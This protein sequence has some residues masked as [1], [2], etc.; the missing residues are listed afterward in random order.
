[1]SVRAFLSA[2]ALTLVLGA[3]SSSAAPASTDTLWTL[4]RC[5]EAALAVSPTLAGTRARADAAQAG[6]S[7]AEASRFPVIGLSGRGGYT[8]ET[9]KLEVP[10]PTGTNSIE[11]GDGSSADL[12]FGLRAPLFT[13]G[14][15]QGEL[16]A[17]KSQRQASL[18][19]IA[20][21]SLEVRLQVRQA[22]F[23]ALGS[24]AA[25]QAAQ[26]GEERLRRHLA[27]VEGNLAVGMASEEARL[28]VLARL[29]RTEQ[30]TLQARAEAAARRY[31]LGQLV[32]L[33]GTQIYPQADLAASLLIGP[34]AERPWEKRPTLQAMDARLDAVSQS[35]RA[36]DGTRWPTVDLEGGWH[37]G[38][39]GIDAV[40]N[41]WMDYGTVAVNLRWT[42]FDFGSRR[43]RVGGLRAQQRALSATRDDVQD[44]LRTR[45]ANAQTQLETARQEV[46]RAAERLDLE[47]RRLEL[48]HE[49]WQEGH[50]T[51]SELL[52]AQDDV[53]LAESD[54]ATAQAR[55]RLTEAELLAA[56]GW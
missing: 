49:R 45:Q 10:T 15:L 51:E 28:Q 37:Y 3:T 55:L 29:L 17:A 44:A 46:G 1:M 36:A 27:D 16:N 19:D 8:T 31:R 39:P 20:A 50:A 33:A 42:L 53:T 32:G 14:R 6:V 47:K 18:A 9:M 26:K 2:V 35:A 38:R 7:V 11:F 4:A 43:H 23:A 5:E 56:R 54:L 41:D 25:A 13:G 21:D 30:A 22:F 34:V 24:E 48:T 40:T 52:D 12:M